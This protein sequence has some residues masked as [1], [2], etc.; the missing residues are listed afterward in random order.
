ML[1]NNYIT[2]LVLFSTLPFMVIS[3]C[4]P[5]TLRCINPEDATNSRALICDPSQN[6]VLFESSCVQQIIPNCL[7]T[8]EQNRCK[9][10]EFGKKI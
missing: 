10:C 9:V 7:L 3:P 6:Y 1:I 8:I 5:G 2:I 4:G